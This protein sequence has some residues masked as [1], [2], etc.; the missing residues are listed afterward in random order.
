MIK[1]PSYLSICFIVLSRMRHTQHRSTHSNELSQL[2]ETSFIWK[3]IPG[4]QNC[5]ITCVR[6][7]TTNISVL[8]CCHSVFVLTLFNF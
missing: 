5:T 2:P 8:P 1:R 6:F 7:M 4:I 3:T